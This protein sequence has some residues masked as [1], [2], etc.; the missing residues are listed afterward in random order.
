MAVEQWG[1]LLSRGRGL[2]H[3]MVP[4]GA[5]P[6]WSARCRGRRAEAQWYDVRVWNLSA[7]TVSALPADVCRDCARLARAEARAATAA[8]LP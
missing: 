7:Y 2:R 6:L 1:R 4:V 8:R 5:G 3:L